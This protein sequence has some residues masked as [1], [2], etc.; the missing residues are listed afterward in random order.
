MGYGVM[1]GILFIAAVSGI[2]LFLLMKEDQQNKF[3][4][5]INNF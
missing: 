3:L 5:K 4:E 2:G 1:L